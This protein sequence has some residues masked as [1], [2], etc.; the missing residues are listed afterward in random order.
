MSFF[1]IFNMK[2]K[3]FLL[4]LLLP[5]LALISPLCL[6][7]T[8]YWLVSLAILQMDMKHCFSWHNLLVILFWISAL[9]CNKDLIKSLV[10]QSRNKLE[11]GSTIYIINHFLVSFFQIATLYNNLWLVCILKFKFAWVIHLRMLLIII[12]GLKLS[13]LVFILFKYQW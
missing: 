1:P 5:V 13:L 2:W 8:E 10:R 7:E 9:L 12:H 11:I 6:P 4:D 3:I